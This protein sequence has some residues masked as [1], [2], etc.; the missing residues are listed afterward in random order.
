VSANA[1]NMSNTAHAGVDHDAIRDAV[2]AAKALVHGYNWDCEPG[3]WLIYRLLLALPYPA[4]VVM[5]PLQGS[6]SP[7][8][9]AA[10]YSLPLA[11]GRVFDATVLSN[12]ALRPLADDWCRFSVRCLRAAGDVVCPLRSAAEA[13][14][15]PARAAARE[16]AAR[17]GRAV[18]AQ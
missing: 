16:L 4:K 5:P 10:Q 1:E 18:P 8:L 12:D 7:V 14:R 2:Q 13:N 3:R 17:P 9:P 15:E 11:M 6:T